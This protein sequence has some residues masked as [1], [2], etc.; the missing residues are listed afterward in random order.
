MARGRRIQRKDEEINNEI[1]EMMKGK[2]IRKGVT[3]ES[4][5][6]TKV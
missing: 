1:K 5:E 2:I 6:P 4:T 3:K